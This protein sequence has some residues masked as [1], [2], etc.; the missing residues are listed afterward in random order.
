MIRNLTRNTVLAE[1]ERLADRWFIR[2]RG[3]IGHDFSAFDGMVFPDCSAIHTFFMG[4]KID[5]LFLDE[6]GMVRRAC[7]EVPPWK[8]C[9]MEKSASVTVE[10]PAGTISGTQTSVG[11][12]I[13]LKNEKK[14][15]ILSGDLKRGEVF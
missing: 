11:D 3:M 4:M 12:F 1:S 15:A 2:L 9:L 14:N 6:N 8:C 7:P 10:L 13:G 5:V